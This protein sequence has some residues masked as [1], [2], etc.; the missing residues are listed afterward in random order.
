MKNDNNKVKKAYSKKLA[1]WIIWGDLILS[2]ATLGISALAILRDYSGSLPYLVS[3]IGIYN[4]STA[5][6]L[7]KYFDKSTKEN[8]KGGIVYDT[9]MNQDTCDT[10]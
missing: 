2:I 7:G 10:I 1:A 6:V 3:L 5:Y 9:A 8:I 4:M